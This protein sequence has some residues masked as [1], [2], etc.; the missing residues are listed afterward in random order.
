[1]HSRMHLI[2]FPFFSFFISFQTNINNVYIRENVTLFLIFF[3]WMKKCLLCQKIDPKLVVA[4][5]EIWCTRKRRW[6]RIAEYIYTNVLTF[7]CPYKCLFWSLSFRILFALILLFLLYNY[8]YLFYS[9]MLLSFYLASSSLTFPL[10]I[11]FFHA[12]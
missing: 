9:W 5:V 11:S 10:F 12:T 6:R 2:L 7:I 8:P 4:V 3:H 1:M